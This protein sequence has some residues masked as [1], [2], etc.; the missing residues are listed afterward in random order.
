MIA[1]WLRG[2]LTRFPGRL[3]GAAA[4][5]ALTVALCGALAVQIVAGGASMT[6]QAIANVDV[7]WQV[8]LNPAAS[9]SD[10]RAA[11]AHATRVDALEAVWFAGVA[12]LES[13]EGGTVQTT[14]PGKVVGLDPSYFAAFPDE[15]HGS[16]GAP[17]GVLLFG[18][19]AA[20]LHATVGSTVVLTRVGLPAAR[21]RVDGI[22]SMPNIDTFF[23][24]VGLPPGTAPQAPPDNVVLLPA[25][26]WH[27]LFDRQRTVRPD[28]VREQ[29][30][31]RIAHDALPAD[32][33]A[34]YNDVS[35]KARNVEA[36][37]AG[38]GSIGDNLA[39]R[40]LGT[41]ADALYARVLFLFLGVPGVVLAALLTFTV[42]A[43]GATRR[44]GETALLR[45]RGASTRQIVTL[46]AVEAIVVGVAGTL[47]G[48]LL[49]IALVPNALAAHRTLLAVTACGGLLLA[50]AAV[51]L[52]A[53]HDAHA[54]TVAQSRATIGR[55]GAPFWER[56]FL[57]V[58]LLAIA[59]IAFWSTASTG[60][61]V[62]LAPEGVPQASVHYEAFLAP[63][64]L[65]F[66][67]ALLA[68]RLW[69]LVL[70]RGRGLL[71]G[72][73]R[74]I[75][76][77][78]A[79][80]VAASLARQHR[81]VTRAT[82][83]AGLA[84]AF[85]VSTAVFNS[86]Y[87]AQSR[88]D[89]ELT[90]GADVSVTGTTDAPP[91][92]RLDALRALP[93]VAAA[94]SMQHRYAFVGNDLQDLYGIHARTIAQATPMS[95]AFFGGGDAAATL[96][97]LA[98]T[99][100]GVLVSEETVQTYQLRTGDTIVLRLQRAGSHAYV[101]VKFRFIGVTREFPTAPH[102]SF[103]VANANYVAAQTGT[104]AAEIV[105]IR[106]RTQGAIES[107]ASAARRV[108]HDLPGAHVTTIVEAQR[109]IGSSLT[110]V[111]LRALTALELVFAIVFVAAATGLMLALGLAE[112]LRTFAVLAA[113]GAKS[114]QLL[115]FL[116]AEAAVVV[117][118]G[119]V[120]GI[121]LG[122]VIAQVLV[123]VL[124]GVFDPPPEAL[125]V[126]WP[127]IAGLLAA[128]AASTAVAIAVT[129]RATRA[130]V[131]GALREL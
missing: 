103:L 59:G 31:V 131:I 38:S 129:A 41:Q 78:L 42:A 29:L 34:A 51:L 48:T 26:Q 24:A 13:T 1:V 85:G 47:A 110:A 128:A 130:S 112:R 120:F 66:G 97:E 22:V 121:A 14:G 57:D 20:N 36:R 96:A 3:A 52:P 114:R 53:W 115:A 16:I 111:D 8:Q 68:V 99:P 89:A 76:G 113:L 91:S 64:L 28:S 82:L 75:S 40:L 74:G 100:D 92:G 33:L 19:T 73:L 25:P 86:T 126:P 23:Q 62:V 71:A 83:L 69:R 93:N 70:L 43:S 79:T 72:L 49:T 95:N 88:V 124:T 11:V 116:A 27:A 56:T 30:H 46:G 94:E 98:G 105:L 63:V 104:N 44:A 9:E 39:A 87:A 109:K 12:G 50:L 65:W 122:F 90:N 54:N 127:Y 81:L 106:A 123:K 117:I 60:Y 108:A 118:A 107:I 10:V 58:I 37:I 35:G 5:V 77:T 84:L 80:L 15:V 4:G 55:A 125:V 67:A 18:Q 6:R 102:D 45:V 101:P 7:D 21:V 2:I 17:R 119:A 32:P 61:Q